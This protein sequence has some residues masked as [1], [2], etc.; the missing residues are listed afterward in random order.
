MV[1]GSRRWID[2]PEFVLFG[3]R[4]VLEGEAEGSH[5]RSG[6]D[7]YRG[8][9]RASHDEDVPVAGFEP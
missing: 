2:L 3:S 5:R 7:W 1:D 4:Y 6:L 8:G 9:R